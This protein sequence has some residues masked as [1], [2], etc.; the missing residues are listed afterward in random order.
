METKRFFVS[1]PAV[2]VECVVV[3]A[4]DV[5]DALEKFQQLS[6]RGETILEFVDWQGEA[7]ITD[8]SVTN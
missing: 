2:Y 1:V 4:A 7:R 5:G 8:I 3:E 6:E